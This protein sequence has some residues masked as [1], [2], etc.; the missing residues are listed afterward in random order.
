[1][2]ENE[3][4]LTGKACLDKP[5]AIY[6]GRLESS[7]GVDKLCH[8]WEKSGKDNLLHIVGDGSLRVQLEKKHNQNTVF[9]GI[10][11][12]AEL[13]QLIEKCSFYIS[14]SEREGKSLALMEAMSTGL[15]PIVCNIESQYFLT[16]KLNL[17]LIDIDKQNSE[18]I[19]SQ[20]LNEELTIREATSERIVAYSKQNFQG[21]WSK[22]WRLLL[23]YI[24]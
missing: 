5:N 7:K 3:S 8:A 10:K 18:M 4:S 9:H 23:K 20:W 11:T 14:C 17:P 21:N 24:D 12:H 22:Q 16:E 2:I 19:I 6:F 1:V 13:N 15:I